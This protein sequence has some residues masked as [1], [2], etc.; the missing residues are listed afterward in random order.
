MNNA[1][2]YRL[3]NHLLRVG[4][5]LALGLVSCAKTE[6]VAPAPA[7][8]PATDFVTATD[9]GN[10][11]GRNVSGATTKAFLP[12]AGIKALL[13]GGSSKTWML[14]N[15]VDAPIVVGTETNPAEYFP[16]VRAGELPACQVDD[17]YTFTNKNQMVYDAKAATFLA[18]VFNCSPPQ[19]GTSAYSFGYAFGGGLAQ[20]TL[21]R[22]GAFVGTTDASTTEQ[23]YR[24]LS[25]DG[26]RMVL[27]AG[28]G[29]NGGIVFTFKMIA[30]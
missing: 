28:S 24:I 19:S 14:D 12:A 2:P 21:A 7:G 6:L 15:S 25:I 4:L 13:T 27:R 30:K 26:T 23:V 3:Q 17:E 11:A 29:R 16:G 1:Q 20:V 18:G 10:V 5:L 8:T 9:P 22:P